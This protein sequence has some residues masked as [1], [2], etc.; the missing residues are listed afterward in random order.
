M[1]TAYLSSN[2]KTTNARKESRRVESVVPTTGM[3][4][5]RM[6]MGNGYLSSNVKTTDARTESRRVESTIL[7]RGMTRSS[8]RRM[9]KGVLA[10]NMLV[11]RS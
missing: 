10:L 7:A 2:I 5:R 9:R 11:R 8:S 3:P 1:E 6:R 4:T